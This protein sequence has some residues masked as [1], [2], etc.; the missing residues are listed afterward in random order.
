MNARGERTRARLI[1]ATIEVVAEAGYARATTKA[2]ADAAG[3]AEGTIY[4]HFPDK[5]QLFFA[6]VFDRNT[7]V[8]NWIAA[9]PQRAGTGTVAGNLREALGQLGRLRADLLPLELWL[10]SDPELSRDMAAAMV[11]L[12]RSGQPAHGAPAGSVPGV[13]PP[14]GAMP[15]VDV[16]TSGSRGGPSPGEASPV[17]GF[18]AGPL[19][20]DGFPGAMS[21]E[22]GSRGQLP[23]PPQYVAEYLAAERDLGRIGPTT[24]PN[25]VAVLLLVILFGAAMTTTPEGSGV[26][27]A[28]LGFAVDTMMDGIG[29]RDEP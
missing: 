9:F 29:V 22:G 12:Q 14:A 26:D 18:P 21:T 7:A 6:A 25:R 4:R 24:D 5:R 3:V 2:I 19:P 10:R 8:L 28:L 20:G 15:G 13:D 17:D 27:D 16:R 11:D 23:G 1:S